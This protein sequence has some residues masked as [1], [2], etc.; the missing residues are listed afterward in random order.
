MN[1][2]QRNILSC[3]FFLRKGRMNGTLEGR[4]PGLRWGKVGKRVVCLKDEFQINRYRFFHYSV[5]NVIASF[6]QK[7]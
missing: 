6:T 2:R 3:Q 1:C 4:T 7:I 5:V